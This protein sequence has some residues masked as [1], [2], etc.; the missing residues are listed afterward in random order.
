MR[1]R[2]APLVALAGAAALVTGVTAPA[3]AQAPP[4]VATVETDAPAVY[5]RAAQLIDAESGDVLFSKDAGERMPVASLT[6]TMTAYVVMKSTN[7]TDVVRIKAEDVAYAEDGGGTTADLR[8]GDRLTV[9]ELMY[10]LMLPS[11]ADAAH[12]LARTYGPGVKGFVAKM[13]ATARE[14]GMSDTEYVNADGLPTP[15]GDGYSTAADQALLAAKALQV[16]LIKEVAGTRRHTLAATGDHRA[17]SWRNTNRLLGTPGAI[18]LK[19][20]FTRAAGYCLAFAG[21]VEGRRLVGVLLDESVS[22]RRF[23]TAET[24][25][26]WGGS[27]VSA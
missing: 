12:A 9:G 8:P 5:G 11:G 26:S 4:A 16:P 23:S 22:S 15:R 1:I 21:E 10:A 18:G 19:T 2:K 14:L 6:K 3:G 25:L 27:R 24:L 17:Y 13:N 7:P 20:G